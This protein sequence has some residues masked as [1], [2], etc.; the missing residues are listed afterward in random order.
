MH[1]EPGEF[2]T[3]LPEMLQG[4][5]QGRAQVFIAEGEKCVEA[6]WELGL[7]ATCNPSGAGKWKDEYTEH[8]PKGIEIIII[9]DADKPGMNHAGQ[10]A[11]SFL[12]KGFD[13]KII[14]LGYT[15]QDN[16]GDDVYDWL[17]RDGH[18]LDELKK[19][20]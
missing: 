2:L 18:T 17:K 10:V 20:P 13:V 4:F 16:H 5:K 3:G 7:A 11:E 8:F 14:D 15:V 1:G 9:P 6:L 12:N 19:K